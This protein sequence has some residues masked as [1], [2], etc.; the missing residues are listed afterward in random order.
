MTFWRWLQF[1]DRR[2]DAVGILAVHALA[3][4]DWPKRARNFRTLD[5]YLDRCG[6]CDAVRAAL[7]QAYNE[8]SATP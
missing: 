8:W 3:D 2:A 7:K 4:E 1:Q 6:A 5:E